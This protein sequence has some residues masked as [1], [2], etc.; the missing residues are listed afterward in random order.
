MDT[1][2][3]EIEKLVVEYFHA[4]PDTELKRAAAGTYLLRLMSA[5]SRSQFGGKEELYLTFDADRAFYHPDW[6]LINATHPY[7]DVIRNDLTSRRE[8][9]RMGEAH[10]AP[11]PVNPAGEVKVPRIEV[12]GPVSSVDY[13]TDYRPYFVLAYKVV[14]ETDERQDYILRLC[15]DARTGEECPDV[16]G[17]LARLPLEGGKPPALENRGEIADLGHVLRRGRA[18]IGARLR[19][20]AAAIANQSAE[21]LARE[22][23]RLDHHYAREIELTSKRDEE[24]RRKLRENLKREIEDFE[25]KYACR[26]RAS[27][28]SVL[29]LWAPILNYRIGARS[30]RSGFIVDDFAYDACVDIVVADPCPNCGNHA[31][32]RL[33]CAGRHAVCGDTS[34]TATATCSVC[35]DSYCP[36]H[37]R[38]CS[39]CQEPS[40]FADHAACSYGKHPK[41]ARFCTRCTHTSFEKKIIC[42][43]CGVGC[44]LCKR[45]FPQRLVQTCS[46]GGEHFCHGHDRDPDG[47]ICAECRKPVC[48]SHGRKTNDGMWACKRHSQAATCCGQVFGNSRLT[49]CVEDEAE[50]LCPEHRLSCAVCSRSVCQRH[51]VR[52]WQGEPLCGKDAGQCVRCSTQP[53][54]RIHRRDHLQ[55][56]VICHEAVCPEHVQKCAVCMTTVFCAAHAASQPTC[57]SCGRASCG[58]KGCSANASVCMLCGMGYCRNCMTRAGICTTCARPTPLSRGDQGVLLLEKIASMQDEQLK[59]TAQLMLQSFKRCVVLASENRTYRVVVV[60]YQP[61]RWLFWQR[62]RRLR[63]VIT[64][65]GKVFSARLES[66]N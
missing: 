4:R 49:A 17:H 63:A 25:R 61:S 51:A 8:D 60:Q 5:E 13:K 14:F 7:L 24:G 31:Q 21:Q 48:K 6:E 35:Q 1:R 19:V 55:S 50:R 2:Q 45:I 64:R 39:H 44:D 20:E 10:F 57:Q 18:E 36:V 26:S 15:F 27:L 41:D 62:R 28:I 40:C 3:L 11:Q 16:V 53:T 43:E 9:P 34:C 29:L 12:D 32:Y 52:S 33:C 65:G 47:D 56:C 38:E 58:T 30:K 46:V 22:K 23:E 42:A 59:E 54:R 37:G 66:A